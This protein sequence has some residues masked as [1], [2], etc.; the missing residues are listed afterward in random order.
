LALKVV[1]TSWLAEVSPIAR[2]MPII[3]YSP[4]A[5]E[6]T[7][8]SAANGAARA[9]NVPKIALATP[10]AVYWTSESLIALRMRASHKDCTDDHG[11]E[12]PTFF[13]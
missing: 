7:V 1:L 4:L 10:V 11:S 6:R 8:E 2:A 3:D 13:A 5:T 9:L 12:L